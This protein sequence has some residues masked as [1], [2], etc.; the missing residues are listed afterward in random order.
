MKWN[1]APNLDKFA[2]INTD[3]VYKAINEFFFTYK[4]CS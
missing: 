2:H 1:L 4:D 3:K